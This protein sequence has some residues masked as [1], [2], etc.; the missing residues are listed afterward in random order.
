MLGNR[1]HEGD[2]V[3]LD[4]RPGRGDALLVLLQVLEHVAL[5]EVDAVEALALH[6]V[7]VAVAGAAH[8]P[9]PAG[10]PEADRV[11]LRPVR[12]L[13]QQPV[14]LAALPR[15]LP[16]GPIAFR[17]ADRDVG[18]HDPAAAVGL[19]LEA[20]DLGRLEAGLLGAVLGVVDHE[21][22]ERRGRGAGNIEVLQLVAPARHLA[23]G[24]PS[25]VRRWS[26]SRRRRGRPRPGLTCR[27]TRRRRR[28][29][30]DATTRSRQIGQRGS[31]DNN[32]PE[33]RRF[34]HSGSS[35]DDI[36]A[37]I[38]DPP[39]PGITRYKRM[40]RTIRTA[41]SPPFS[42]GRGRHGGENDDRAGAARR[43]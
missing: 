18:Q 28:R 6:P 19:A 21:Q 33:Q 12:V 34:K 5:V 38:A 10:L 13:A 36:R 43:A 23:Q 14:R 15:R 39:A 16:V 4:I 8:Q 31:G 2:H 25:C 42:Q 11:V 37:I 27:G 3:A 22:V 29:G 20:L 17:L 26:L 1:A 41:A 9:L 32:S 24:R 7:E 40:L 30:L 35:R